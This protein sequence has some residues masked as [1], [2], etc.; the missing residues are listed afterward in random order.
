MNNVKLEKE[1][2]EPMRLWLEQYVRDKYKKY[3]VIAIDAHTERLDRVLA[4]YNIVNEMA[5]G[6]DIQIDVL[7]IAR[8][9]TDVKMFFIEAKKTQL[10]LRDLGQLWAYC[11]LVNPDEAYLFSSAGLG[12]LNK[13]LNVFRRDDLLDFGNGKRIQKMKVA[14]WDIGTNAPDMMSM[15]PKI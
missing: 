14:K 10:T 2:Y 6:V 15:I 1:L 4:K 3:D 5:N 8:N 7:A 9:N 12:S 11:K 13:L